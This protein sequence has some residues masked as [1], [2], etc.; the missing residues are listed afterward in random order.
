MIVI[1][2]FKIYGRI[3]SPEI[4]R[5][6]SNDPALHNISIFGVDPGTVP[7]GI[8]R[9]GFFLIRFFSFKSSIP[10]HQGSRRG[11]ILP[12]TTACALPA[13]PYETS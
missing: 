8:S 12:V 6:L 10:W 5:R 2:G 3:Y 13:N 4:Q 1:F 7:T 9:H 11:A